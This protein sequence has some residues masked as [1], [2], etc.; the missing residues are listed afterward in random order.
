M[1][2]QEFIMMDSMMMCM[3]MRIMIQYYP[4]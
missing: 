2:K 1:M 3:M 4:E